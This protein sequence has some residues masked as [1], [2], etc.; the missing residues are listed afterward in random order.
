MTDS[1]TF[2]EE[3]ELV[4]RVVTRSEPDFSNKGE[5]IVEGVSVRYDSE[6]WECYLGGSE[7]AARDQRLCYYI[8]FKPIGKLS[9]FVLTVDKY[10]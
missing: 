2:N 8:D 5:V 3:K 4:E 10:N 7:P 1:F 6:K 9:D